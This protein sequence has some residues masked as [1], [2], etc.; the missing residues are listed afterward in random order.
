MTIAK[1]LYALIFTTLIGL[2][3]LTILS[4]HQLDKVNTDASYSTVNTVPSLLALDAARSSFASIRLAL[5][6]YLGTTDAQM[7]ARCEQDMIK[8]HAKVL[9]ALDQYE[10]EDISNDADRKLLEVDRQEFAMYEKARATAMAMT[11]SGNID[12]AKAYMLS[13]QGLVDKAA[14]AFDDHKEFNVALGKQAG[15][16]AA[17]TMKTA[18]ILAIG[19]ALVIG[20]IV[21]V[22]GLL[23]VRKIVASLNQA[24]DVAKSIAQG[25]LTRQINATSKDEIGQLMSAIS[26]M[27]SSLVNIVG[28][29][30]TSVGAIAT[31]S[32]EIASGN[33]DLSARTE[34]QAGSLE[35]TASAMEELTSTVKQNADN[36]RQANQLACSA[37][38]I[39]SEG[40]NVVRQVVSTMQA[41]NDSARKVVEIISVIDGIAF[42][43]NILAL[44]AAVEAARAGEQGRGFAVVAS[45]V[46]SLAQRSATAAKEIKLLIDDSVTK[47]EDGGKLVAQ[48][49]TTMDEVAAS[50]RRVTDVVSEIS[51]ASNE[52]S[53]GIGQVNQ[54]IAQMDETTQQNAALVEEAAAASQSLREQAGRLEQAV[55]V[56]KLSSTWETV[57]ASASIEASPVV[58][59]SLKKLVT[60]A[61]ASRNTAKV[62]SAATTAR[63]ASMAGQIE[64]DGAWTQF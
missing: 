44:N 56:F 62:S 47:V 24:V 35:E 27:N 17:A 28:D 51:A 7:R 9:E 58:Q 43:T 36:A 59:P 54:A 13:Q 6:R 50:V 42:Q 48:A 12:E 46:R 4:I 14:K 57:H 39:A 18:S 61:V 16:T 33:L 22:S 8:G 63:A 64:G 55:A 34:T 10:K 30:R 25:D 37:S 26:E 31:A 21:A 40:G 23:L 60:K 3:G 11:A 52:Q 5:W 1:K 15:E 20:G 49:G 2:F 32:S 19:V 29:V 53:D 41:I 38:D 45:E